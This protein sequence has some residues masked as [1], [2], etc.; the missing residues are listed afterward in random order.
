MLP[1]H[2]TA[3]V[4]SQNNVANCM[5]V[6]RCLLLYNRGMLVSGMYVV[7]ADTVAKVPLGGRLLPSDPGAI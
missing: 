1:S 5:K 2:V 4:P 6:T 3:H 7:A